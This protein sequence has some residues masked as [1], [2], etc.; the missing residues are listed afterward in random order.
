MSG[1]VAGK[2]GRFSSRK[3][4]FSNALSHISGRNGDVSSRNCRH[5]EGNERGFAGFLKGVKRLRQGYFRHGDGILCRR[6]GLQPGS[7]YH[8]GLG[9]NPD[10]D[11]INPDRDGINPVRDG[12]N[13]VRHGINPVV[14]KNDRH[15]AENAELK[16][17]KKYENSGFPAH[18]TRHLPIKLKLLTPALSSFGEEREKMSRRRPFLRHVHNPREMWEYVDYKLLRFESADFKGGRRFY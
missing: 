1:Y 16:D 10:R 12:I 18:G 11:G 8:P 17:G 4:H 7:S 3:N 5:S 14:H 9:I 2:N 15:P 6:E 13:P